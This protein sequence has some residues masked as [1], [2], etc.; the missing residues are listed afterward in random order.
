[1]PAALRHQVEAGDKLWA[2]FVSLF[3]SPPVVWAIW[4][5]LI[6]QQF[7]R[8]P[9]EA[10]FFASLFALTICIL[11]MAFVAYMVRIGR[12]SDMHMRHSHE[13]Y[14]PYSI[15]IV[16][17]LMTELVYVQFGASPVL[18]V[19]ALVTIVELTIMLIGTFFSHI[20]LHA[21]AMSSIIAATT[22]VYGFNK[23][24]I[25]IPVLLLVVLARLAL[26]RH[27]AWQIVLGAFIGVCTP[28]VVIAG[29]SLAIP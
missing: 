12:I 6:A 27:T 18:V 26:R 11:P 28:L 15:A 10:A 7:S 24:L 3:I 9:F 14:I 20:S 16:G 1:M 25:F 21:M 29:L 23:S 22:I 17:C 4:V 13:R 8:S 19:V 2:H 5:L